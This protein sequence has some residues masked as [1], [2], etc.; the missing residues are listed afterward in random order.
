ML[1]DVR[2]LARYRKI[3]FSDAV[4]NTGGGSVSSPQAIAAS[5]GAS[6]SNPAVISTTAGVSI[7]A[8]TT[9]GSTAAN[10][11]VPA[12]YYGL[13]YQLQQVLNQHDNV[14]LLRV[15]KDRLQELVAQ[16]PFRRLPEGAL[17]E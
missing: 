14:D 17:P 15:Q 11:T 7:A 9:V 1:Y 5:G 6:V 4:V 16:T 3:F 10:A 12:G 13:L 2:T 8:G